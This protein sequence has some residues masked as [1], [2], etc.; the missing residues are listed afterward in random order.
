MSLTVKYGVL[1]SILIALLEGYVLFENRSASNVCLIIFILMSLAP[2][3]PVFYVIFS[4]D[5]K[6]NFDNISNG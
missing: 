6:Q 4:Y 5:M 2:D 3:W 1:L